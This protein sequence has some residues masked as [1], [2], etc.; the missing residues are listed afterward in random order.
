MLVKGAV[1]KAALDA[2]AH[3]VNDVSALRLDLSLGEVCA[4]VGAGLVLMHSRGNVSD[5]G[6]YVSVARPDGT[7]YGEGQGVTMTPDG[8]MASWRGQ[9]RGRFTGPGAVSWRGALY[10]D[11]TSPQLARLTGCAV[12]YEYDADASGKTD[13]KYWEW[14]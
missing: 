1:A 4:S 3:I 14:K 8:G 10:Y 5:M 6:T 2:G 7:L 12:V 9:G 11:T 13:A